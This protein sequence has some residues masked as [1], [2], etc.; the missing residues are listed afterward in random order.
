MCRRRGQVTP[1]VGIADFVVKATAVPAGSC[2]NGHEP[3][4]VQDLVISAS[5][6]RY[7]RER[8]IT[9]DGKAG[10]RSEAHR[11]WNTR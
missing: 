4:L 6:L 3:F 7:Q 1:R 9:P 2:F 10:S 5:A 8:W 11:R